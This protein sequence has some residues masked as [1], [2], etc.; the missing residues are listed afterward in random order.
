M[1]TLLNPLL[2]TLLPL[3]LQNVA[4]IPWLPYCLGSVSVPALALR[5]FVTGLLA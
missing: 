3:L 5:L 2:S 4:L 1:L